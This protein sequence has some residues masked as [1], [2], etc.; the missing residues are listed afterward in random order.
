MVRRV[1]QCLSWISLAA[2]LLPS[3][4]FLA[5]QCSLDECS[6]G[7]MLATV[8]WFVITPLWMGREKKA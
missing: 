1:L 5:G 6:Q 7:M 2:T 8:V 3:L 4:M